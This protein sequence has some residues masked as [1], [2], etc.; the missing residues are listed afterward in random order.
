MNLPYDPKINKMLCLKCRGIAHWN[1]NGDLQCIEP[2][3]QYIYYMFSDK[4]NS[5]QLELF[6]E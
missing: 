1:H 4:D 6:N 2:D 3:C 5:F